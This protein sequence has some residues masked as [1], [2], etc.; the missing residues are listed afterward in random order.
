MI[1]VRVYRDHENYIKKYTVEGHANFD[2]YGKD[3]VCAA[4]SVLA[5]T[6]LLALVDVCGLKEDR[7]KYEID[8]NRG[9][10]NVELPI[11]IEKPE[12]DKTQI[13]LETFF[14]GIKSII[15][16]YPEYVKLENGRCKQ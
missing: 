1:I 9:F 4:V 13:V 5:Q 16:S 10:L 15:E 12:L 3:I 7:I 8:D 2:E 6:T 14:L 11:D